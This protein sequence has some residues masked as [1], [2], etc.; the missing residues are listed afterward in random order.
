[1]WKE[2][3]IN[4]FYSDRMEVTERKESSGKE[5]RTGEGWWQKKLKCI[6]HM[7]SIIR[8]AKRGEEGRTETGVT[9]MTPGSSTP[10]SVGGS[11]VEEINRP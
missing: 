11:I 2:G 9:A 8:K 7:L 1:M 3:I 5:G 6:D 4:I 10:E